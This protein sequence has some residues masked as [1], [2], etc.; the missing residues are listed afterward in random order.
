M[1][2]AGKFRADSGRVCHL[3]WL[4]QS[5]QSGTVGEIAR[6]LGPLGD[7]KFCYIFNRKQHNWSHI[8]VQI[9]W[10]WTLRTESDRGKA[11]AERPVRRH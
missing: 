6:K 2:R 8:L 7:P 9:T 1:K 4:E 3:V 11:E 5:M 10:Q